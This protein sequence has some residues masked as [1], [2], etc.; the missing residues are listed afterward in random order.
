MENIRTLY[1]DLKEPFYGP[2]NYYPMLE[3]FDAEIVISVDDRDY[4][5]D[6]YLLY[7][8]GDTYGVLIFGW[9]SC[10]GCDAL[11][12]CETYEQLDQLM[13]G[14]YESIQWDSLENTLR[15]FEN[16][17][18]EGDYTWHSNECRQWVQECKEYL[19]GILDRD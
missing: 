7:R 16:H 9:G 6:S 17:D 1:P 11:Q 12:A 4:Q 3:N 14:L 10:S 18:W 19:H 15:Y 13:N 2:G 5:G 8:R